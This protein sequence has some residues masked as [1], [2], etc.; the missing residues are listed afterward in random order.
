VFEVSTKALSTR[1][2]DDLTHGTEPARDPGLD[3]R[4]SDLNGADMQ[5]HSEATPNEG[6]A[7]RGRTPEAG[8]RETPVNRKGLT[9]ATSK[10]RHRTMERE[11]GMLLQDRSLLDQQNAT[12]DPAA[13]RFTAYPAAARKEP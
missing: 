11:G 5:A 12:Q 13:G 3:P 1:L 10:V 4:V 8:M 2:T 7:E 6:L 9:F